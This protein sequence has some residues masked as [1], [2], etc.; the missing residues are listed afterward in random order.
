MCVCR[1]VCGRVVG[2]G[3]QESAELWDTARRSADTTRAESSIAPDAARRPYTQ[4]YP[5]SLFL[6]S[7]RSAHSLSR[8]H[9][10]VTE[11]SNKCEAVIQ[12]NAN[13]L[14]Y[15]NLNN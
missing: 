12:N 5:L 1:R 13:K 15:K 11:E 14:M 9:I 6:R 3:L 4:H 2:R 8:E 10:I 7:T